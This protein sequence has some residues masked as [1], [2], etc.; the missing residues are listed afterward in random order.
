MS[1]RMND[2]THKDI[3]DKVNAFFHDFARQTI[4]AAKA[5]PNNPQAVKMAMLDHFEEIYPRFST[6]EIFHRCN[7]TALHEIM[8]EEYRDNFN[9]LLSGFLP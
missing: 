8:V 1:I 4:M 3:K 6:T 2:S 7:G 5:D 9:L